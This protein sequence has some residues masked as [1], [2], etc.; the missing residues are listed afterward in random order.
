MDTTAEPPPTMLVRE[1]EP[2]TLA[3]K[4]VTDRY[5]VPENPPDAVT[6]A[7]DE[8]VLPATTVTALGDAPSVNEGAAAWAVATAQKQTAKAT[9]IG[10]TASVTRPGR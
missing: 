1:S 3:G 4:P 6:V 2:L 10:S 8:V 5:T 7:V 9:R